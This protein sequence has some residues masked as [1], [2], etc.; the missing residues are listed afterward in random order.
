M[1]SFVMFRRFCTILLLPFFSMLG[2][3]SAYAQSWE[4]YFKDRLHELDPIEG[5]WDQESVLQPYNAVRFY[6]E[7]FITRHNQV[8]IC[9]QSERFVKYVDNKRVGEFIKIGDTN[10]YTYTSNDPTLNVTYRVYLIDGTYFSIEYNQPLN[11]E[12]KRAFRNIPGF[13]VKIDLSCVKKFPTQSLFEEFKKEKT[14]KVKNWTGT[15]FAL[16]NN[17]VVTNYHV[18]EG[19]KSIL[20]QGINGN[21]SSKHSATIAATDKV[22][23]LA[24]LRVNGVN[25]LS[26]NIPYSIKTSTS[27]VGEEIF[28]LGYPLTS[29]MGDE[30]KLTTG[31]VSSKTGFQGDVS[32][33]QISA[34]IQPGNSG[35][36]LFDSKGN[37]IGIVSAKHN[38]AENVGYAIKTSYLR[39]LM[40]SVIPLN[41]FPQ[42]N[43]ISTQNLSGK[44]KALKNYVYYIA[45]SSEDNTVQNSSML[46]SSR[47]AVSTSKIVTYPFV[48]SSAAEHARIKKVILDKDYTAIEITDNSTGYDWYNID[49]NTCIMINGAQYK[50]T[51]AEG[52]KISPDITYVSRQGSNIAFTLFF[53]AIPFSTKSIDLIESTDSEWRFYG[54]QIR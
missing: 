23:D 37:V 45:C 42:T 6:T 10:V 2:S 49:K 28:V 21:F 18:V 25:V 32:L 48:R 38:G 43:C 53:P 50:M 44:V 40:E 15:G 11:E 29:T 9:K 51:K 13:G 7:D 54:I 31:V 33:Y 34:P 27:D 52:I 24:I 4:K 47:S 1:G 30:I 46:N 3:V 17:Y 19:A 22:N 8:V 36:P 5:I 41:V 12:Q 26:T 16:K 39:N 14:E 35:G 20:I